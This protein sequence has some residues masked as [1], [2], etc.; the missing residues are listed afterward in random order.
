[1]SWDKLLKLKNDG[2]MSF[3]SLLDFNL[4]LLGKQVRR[5]MSNPNILIFTIYKAKYF[6]HSD[7]LEPILG[8]NPSFIWRSI[9]SSKFILIAS[10]RWRIGNG[11]DFPLLNENWLYDAS[12]VSMQQSIS[13]FD[14]TLTVAA[15]MLPDK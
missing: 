7:F 12:S 5:I 8:H 13:A 2:G 3:K 9:C 1:L 10:S 6:P 11:R 4:T 15:M 14:V